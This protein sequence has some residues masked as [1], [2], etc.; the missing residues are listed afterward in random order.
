MPC[1]VIIFAIAG[2][3]RTAPMTAVVPTSKA[4]NFWAI[5]LDTLH[6]DFLPLAATVQ[7]GGSRVASGPHPPVRRLSSPIMI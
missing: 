2:A 4:H 7:S 1:E 3:G 6:M 5:D